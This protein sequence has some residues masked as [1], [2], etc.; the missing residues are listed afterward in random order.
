[1]Q[2][3]MRQSPWLQVYIFAHAVIENNIFRRSTA[4]APN[5]NTVYLTNFRTNDDVVSSW[6]QHAHNQKHNKENSIQRHYRTHACHN[7][8]TRKFIH[9]IKFFQVQTFRE[10]FV[11]DGDNDGCSNRMYR[12]IRLGRMW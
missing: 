2:I 1:M 12:M 10:V 6:V 4:V 8:Q 7:T 3:Q 5:F 9:N 11:V